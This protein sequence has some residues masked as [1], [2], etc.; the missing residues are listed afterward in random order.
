MAEYAALKAVR[1]RALQS[2]I[3]ANKPMST[4]ITKEEYA[5]LYKIEDD[6]G[7]IDITPIGHVKL[8]WYKPPTRA[9][10]QTN[11]LLLFNT[12]GGSRKFYECFIRENS[13]YYRY[14]SIGTYGRVGQYTSKRISEL[15]RLLN[16]KLANGY[17]IMDPKNIPGYA[18]DFI[19]PDTGLYIVTSKTTKPT[20][21]V[22]Y[23]L[24]KLDLALENSEWDF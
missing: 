4:T 2:L 10:I 18:S 13:M 14:G 19:P 7:W 15:E 5:R 12:E 9:G 3:R 21:M 23:K 16:E 24:S 1:D 17:K 20:D 6:R 8:Q 11:K 22:Q